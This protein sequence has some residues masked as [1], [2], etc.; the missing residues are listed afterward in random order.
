MVQPLSLW[1]KNINE[2]IDYLVSLREK[3]GTSHVRPEYLKVFMDGCVES[4]TGSM[5]KPYKNG[6]VYNSHWAVDR[7]ADITRDCNAKG[8]TVHTHTMGDKA[9]AIILQTEIVLMTHSE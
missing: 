7:L 8:L 6:I 1:Q 3:Y 2:Q 4:F 9:I 5:F